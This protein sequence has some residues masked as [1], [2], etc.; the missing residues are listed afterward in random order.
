MKPGDEF[1]LDGIRYRV[2]YQ[3]CGDF[4]RS[5]GKGVVTGIGFLGVEVV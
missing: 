4:M 5:D 3:A 1:T 2:I